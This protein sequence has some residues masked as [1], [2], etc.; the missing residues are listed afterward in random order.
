M[1]TILKKT[2]LMILGEERTYIGAQAAVG[3][4]KSC[5]MAKTVRRAATVMPGMLTAGKSQSS[6]GG[7]TYLIVMGATAAILIAAGVAAQVA[8]KD[9]KKEKEEK[10]QKQRQTKKKAIESYY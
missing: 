6:Q 3:I 5:P 9:T 10:K 2:Y 1:V 4:L 7:F 8:Y